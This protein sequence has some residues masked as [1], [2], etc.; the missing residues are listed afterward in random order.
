MEQH[1][2]LAES[3]VTRNGSLV[4][5]PFS[6]TESGATHPRTA[7][8]THVFQ[9]S[10]MNDPI[11]DDYWMR[12]KYRW[13]NSVSAAN[14]LSSDSSANLS[15]QRIQL[16]SATAPIAVTGMRGAGKSAMY[17]G[18]A[19][20]SYKAEE[21]PKDERHKIKIVRAN[22]KGVGRK[23]RARLAVVP[24]QAD[25]GPR[26]KAL[27]RIFEDG[28]YPVGVVH[29]VNWGFAEVWDSG[30][31]QQILSYLG[32]R[33]KPQNLESVCEYLRVQE[34]DD[35]RRTRD[36]L[37]SAWAGKG[38]ETWL[39]IAVAKCDLYW[40]QIDDAELYYIPGSDPAQDGDFAKM[41]RSF[42]DQVKV[43]KLAV[44]PVSSIPGPFAFSDQVRAE[45]E[46]FD[47][48]WRA[49]LLNQLRDTLGE[50]NAT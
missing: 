4:P 37:Q 16:L 8:V 5:L 3:A 19:E 17:A 35:F 7:N 29:V 40:Q 21:S 18:L 31:R 36:L 14:D 43:L 12:V 44:L 27:K 1:R 48:R 46:K 50:F 33:K 30:G 25:S 24:G 49:A 23:I 34:L 9:G 28:S 20:V 2:G 39:I 6:K 11:V 41:L 32:Y 42:V 38:A 15:Q 26:Q 10:S 22:V 47:D 13:S 45:P